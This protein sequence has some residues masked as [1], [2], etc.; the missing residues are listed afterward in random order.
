MVLESKI[1]KN[2]LDY[3]RTG[4]IYQNYRLKRWRETL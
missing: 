3:G 4:K 2:T 1:C